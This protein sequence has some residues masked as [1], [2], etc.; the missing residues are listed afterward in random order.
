MK[1]VAAVL[2]MFV[3][4]VFGVLGVFSGLGSVASAVFAYA[5]ACLCV[6]AA[7]LTAARPD[8]GYRAAIVPWLLAVGY[9]L[10]WILSSDPLDFLLLLP[11]AVLISSTAALAASFVAR[12]PA[13][14]AASDR[15]Q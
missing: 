5:V 1:F 2:W 14:R 12:R 15:A 4:G 13:A 6:A 9:S 3:A 7:V 8:M 10:L 11:A